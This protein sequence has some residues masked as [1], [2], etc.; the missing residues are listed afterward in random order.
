MRVPSNPRRNLA[1]RA[2]QPGAS[3]KEPPCPCL[4]PGCL[5]WLKHPR[6]CAPGGGGGAGGQA[7][8]TAHWSSGLWGYCGG[9]TTR[10]LA[11]FIDLPPA[12]THYEALDG[13]VL[14]HHGRRGLAAD[15]LD[16][17][18]AMLAPAEGCKQQPL[19]RGSLGGAKEGSRRHLHAP[20]APIA[21]LLRHDRQAA[22]QRERRDVKRGPE[23]CVLQ[24]WT[25]MA[26]WSA[27]VRVIS[28]FSL[29]RW[30]CTSIKILWSKLDA[31]VGQF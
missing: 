18:P 24:S 5:A 28:V 31:S 9:R 17:A 4:P 13:L 12:P 14:G 3:H 11:Q 7:A 1:E 26:P 8:A 29:P 25:P 27:M 21:P 22:A 20:P 23:G 10:P 16:V 6:C 30:L 19:V 15:P 2:A